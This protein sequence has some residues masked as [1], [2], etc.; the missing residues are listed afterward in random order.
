MQ[1]EFAIRVNKWKQDGFYIDI[2]SCGAYSSN[3]TAM[4]DRIGWK[5]ICIEKEASYKDSYAGRTCNFINEDALKIDY[6]HLFSVHNVPSVVD[7]LSVDIDQLSIDVIKMLPHDFYRFKCITIEHDAYLYADTYREQQRNFLK[8][9]GYHLLCSNVFVEQP[10]F[11]GKQFPFEDWWID[12]K[13]TSISDFKDIQCDYDF[14][15]RIIAR[16]K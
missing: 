12:S 9:N 16:F 8:N 6:K 3:N 2:G 7:Y 4:L 5:G 11:E 1:D 13:N 14:P 10:G 15:S